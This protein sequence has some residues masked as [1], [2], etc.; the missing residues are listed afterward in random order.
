MR[1]G[2]LARLSL[3]N[4]LL[5]RVNFAKQKR[6]ILPPEEDMEE[7]VTKQLEI[8]E[9]LVQL[10]KVTLNLLAQYMSVEEYEY[11]L[12]KITNGDDVII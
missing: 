2:P 8:I 1:A 6:G 3:V 9:S 5:E 12:A 7:L 10:N 4:H 11:L